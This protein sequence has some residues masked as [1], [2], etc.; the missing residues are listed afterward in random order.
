MQVIELIYI[1][2]YIYTPKM[3]KKEFMTI[4]QLSIY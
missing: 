3:V 1:Q 4:Y 2:I